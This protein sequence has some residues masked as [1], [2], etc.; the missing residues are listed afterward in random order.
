MNNDTLAWEDL[1]FPTID[2]DTAKD[3]EA[4]C[5]TPAEEAAKRLGYEDFSYTERS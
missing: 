3:V 1:I 2:H 5:L 4:Q